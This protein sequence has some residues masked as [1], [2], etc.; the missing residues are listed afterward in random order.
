MKWKVI[1]FI[2]TTKHKLWVFWYLLGAC[3]A[4]LWRAIVHDLS[5]YSKAEAPYFERSLPKLRSLEYGSDEYMAAV[6]SLG[7]ALENHYQKNTHHPEHWTCGFRGMSPLDR[8][9]MLCDW[10]AATRRHATGN[11]RKSLSHNKERFGYDDIDFDSLWTDAQEIGL[12]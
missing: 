4:L 6:D 11:M 10:R 9:E 7:P 1:N 2:E 3:R 12:L 8:I 5:K